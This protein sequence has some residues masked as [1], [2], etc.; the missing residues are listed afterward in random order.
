MKTFSII[1]ILLSLVGIII[2]ILLLIAGSNLATYTSYV[3][4]DSSMDVIGVVLGVGGTLLVINLFF[5][6]FSIVAAMASFKKK[7]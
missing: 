7:D 3:S 6:T 1:G 4:D 2:S 5:F